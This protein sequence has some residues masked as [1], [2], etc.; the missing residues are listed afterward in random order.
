MPARKRMPQFRAIVILGDTIYLDE[1]S[2]RFCNNAVPFIHWLRAQPRCKS[3]RVFKMEDFKHELALN[4]LFS[5]PINDP[6]LILYHGHGGRRSWQVNDVSTILYWTLMEWLKQIHAPLLIINDCCHAGALI[7]AVKQTGFSRGK[8]GIIA[9]CPADR[10]VR[11]GLQGKIL[12]AWRSKKPYDPMPQH[13]RGSILDCFYVVVSGI[14]RPNG[15]GS[16]EDTE[17]IRWG[18]RLDHYF[19]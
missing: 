19:F 12:T 10:E 7:D 13:Y 2:G 11:P 6:T 15:N 4:V 9:A 3:V 1:I 14:Q 17:T 16:K 8:I 5:K 18:A